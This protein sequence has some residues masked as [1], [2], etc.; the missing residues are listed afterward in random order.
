MS[1]NQELRGFV[2]EKIEAHV[3]VCRSAGKG[4]VAAFLQTCPG[5]LGAGRLEGLRWLSLRDSAGSKSH[6]SRKAE[7]EAIVSC[8]FK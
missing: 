2:K 6:P 3:T 7:K 1:N 8:H 4:W 5:H